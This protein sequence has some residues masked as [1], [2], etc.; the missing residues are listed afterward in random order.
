MPTRFRQGSK[1]CLKRGDQARH[2]SPGWL[3]TQVGVHLDLRPLL[4]EGQR[5]QTL[6]S[7][8]F[9]KTHNS[10]VF[11]FFL[12]DH[13]I[14]S[15]QDFPLNINLNCDGGCA[16]TD[17]QKVEV[18]LTLRQLLQLGVHLLQPHHFLLQLSHHLVVPLLRRSALL[19]NAL[20]EF[21][22]RLSQELRQSVVERVAVVDPIACLFLKET[23]RSSTLKLT[24][25][26]HIQEGWE[27]KS[28]SK[29]LLRLTLVILEPACSSL[30]FS[31]LSS[32]I[33]LMFAI[34][35]VMPS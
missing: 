21:S 23:M 17:L 26:G 6:Q 15:D 10:T 27:K 30:I 13:F 1:L 18:V 4:A 24:E 32:I 14:F 28:D 25:G 33:T 29:N 2:G 34:L 7:L 5:A 9:A 31:I 3:D 11:I 22:M 20:L 8:K 35:D 16:S 12:Q 19:L